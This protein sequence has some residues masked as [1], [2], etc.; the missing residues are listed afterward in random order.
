MLLDPVSEDEDE[1]AI[2]GIESPSLSSSLGSN[3]TIFGL[4]AIAHSLQ[5]FHPSP[6][7]SAA[8]FALFAENVAPLICIFHMPT[9]T[10]TYW[11]AIASPALVDKNT[12]ALLFAIYYSAIISIT[13]SQCL[14][15]LG[16]PRSSALDYYRFSAEQAMARANLLTTQSTTL[17]QAT[18]LYISALRNHDDSCAAWSLTGLVFHIAQAMG[19]HRDGTLFGLPPFDTEMRRRLWWQI[20]ILDSRGSEYHG[21]EPIVAGGQ[22]NFD[23]RMPLHVNDVDISPEMKASPAER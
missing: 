12:E 9:L 6:S 1:H 7:Q 22:R 15:L 19:L 11:D 2:L 13:A 23:T 8:L 20:C 5:P 14:S 10:S 3:V 17:L 18:T 21:Y 4:R 16:T